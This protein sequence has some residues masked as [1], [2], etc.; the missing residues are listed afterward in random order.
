MT[1]ESPA[2]QPFNARERIPWPILLTLLAELL[3]SLSIYA[4]LRQWELDNQ[5]LSFESR[6]REYTFAIQNDLGR[7][8]SVLKGIGDSVQL[9]GI[10]DREQFKNLVSPSLKRHQS[11]QAISWDPVI[12]N[13]E[14]PLFVSK[15]RQEGLDSF[16]FSERNSRQELVR[17][18][19]RESYVVVYFIEPLQANQFALGYDIASNPTRQR[20]IKKAFRSGGM[21]ATE[22]ITLVQETGKQYAVLILVPIYGQAKPDQK[23]RVHQGLLVGVLRFGDVVRKALS[24]FETAPLNVQL[25]DISKDIAPQSLLYDTTDAASV[26]NPQCVNCYRSTFQ[27][28]QRTWQLSF[29]PNNTEIASSSHWQ[30]WL[31]ALLSMLFSL[32][33]CVYLFMRFK[34]TQTI[35]QQSHEQELLNQSLAK[36]INERQ[37]A[38]SMQREGELYLKSITDNIPVAAVFSEP[39]GQV[40]Y[41]N[42]R[43]QNEFSMPFSEAVGLNFSELFDK[44][45]F[46]QIRPALT[47][48]KLGQKSSF[49][50]NLNSKTK[51]RYYTGTFIPQL[52][53]E[54]LV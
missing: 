14:R 4:V 5:R 27:F 45:T 22:R 32:T 43:F 53:D 49:E 36:E 7:F 23:D 30:S 2:S 26:H 9:Y 38:E 31:T 24:R 50:F 52:T 41:V 1:E 17:A 51:T 37:R 21:M 40:K 28:C 10:E 6:V 46:E 54:T 33:V 15:A 12:S 29:H 35:K 11:I 18:S 19:S 47:K 16:Q 8:S 44:D 34:H 3:I 39:N 42:A 48:V 25:K 20:A 13:G